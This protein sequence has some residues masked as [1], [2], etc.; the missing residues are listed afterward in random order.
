MTQPQTPTASPAS[1]PK[2]KLLTAR[3]R[4][5][6]LVLAAAAGLAS[7]WAYGH[8][9][10]LRA[11][12]PSDKCVPSSITPC[13]IVTD[14]ANDKLVIALAL[15]AGVLALVGVL[16]V[17][18]NSVKAGDIELTSV[19]ETTKDEAKKKTD[20][21][22]TGEQAAVTELVDKPPVWDGLPDWVQ[23]ALLRWANEG[24]ALTAPLRTA[25]IEGAKESGRGNRPWFVTVR[26]DDNSLRTLTIS[27]GRGSVTIN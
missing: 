5:L 11:V 24:G 7:V 27:T 16:G 23:D 1:D 25:V 17:R 26:L 3:E 10:P 14:A 21:K 22:V 12:S 8:P 4:G 15:I 20:G 2:S 9:Q 19:A 6:A 13:S 18:F